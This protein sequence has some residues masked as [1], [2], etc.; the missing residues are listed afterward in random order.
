MDGYLPALPSEEG[1]AAK[2]IAFGYQGCP[3]CFSNNRK[4][5]KNKFQQTYA[6]AYETTRIKVAR[7]RSLEYEVC[8]MWECEFDALK[9]LQPEIA[10]YLDTHRIMSRITLN[11][12]GAFFGGRT[13]NI[14]TS[15]TVELGEEIKYTDICFFTRTYVKEAVSQSVI[16]AFT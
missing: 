10:R 16:R 11:P 3:R 5:S 14:V 9:K 12:R 1:A 15:C 13:E 4:S 2:G 7:M 6:Q 8:E